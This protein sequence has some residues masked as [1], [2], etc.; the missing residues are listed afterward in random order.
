MVFFDEKTSGFL[1][2][3]LEVVYNILPIYGVRRKK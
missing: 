2:K 3:N 1:D